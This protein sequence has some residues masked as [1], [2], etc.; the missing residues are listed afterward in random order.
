MI[1]IVSGL[2]GSG[3]STLVEK[4]AGHFS[5]KPVFASDI[6][7][8]LRGKEAGAIDTENTKKGS[9]FWESEEGRK[10][11]E[12]REKNLDFDRE[13]DEE[14]LRIAGSGENLIFDSRTL[15][16]LFKGK[17]FRVW[18]KA[19]V[20]TC[21]QRISGRDGIPTEEVLSDLKKRFE[22]DKRIYKA[23]YGFDLG[24]DFSPFNLVLD[25]EKLDA[26]A[27]FNKAVEEI[28]KAK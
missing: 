28:E 7:A 18:L 12:E 20:E 22:T 15:P 24:D 6:L 11:V 26:G 5:L 8:Q 25:S 14:L 27:V 2:P 23:L 4:L 1:V 3:K 21:A 17:A 9:G 16:W 13:L 19:S 10:Y